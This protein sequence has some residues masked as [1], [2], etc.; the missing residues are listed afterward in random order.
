MSVNKVILIGN[1][2]SDPEVKYLDGNKVVANIRLATSE[3]YKDKDGQK[4]TQ[5]EWH[6]LELWDELAKFSEKYLKKGR[7]I[8][9]E[10]KIK[11]DQWQDKDGNNRYSTKIRVNTLTLLRGGDPE[12]GLDNA[13]NP[14]PQGAKSN[15]SETTHHDDMADDLPF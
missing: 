15:K 6:S 13:S 5:T 7:E 2:G 10:G 12:T 9:I 8:Y 4:I 3:S 1:L 11:T 14:S